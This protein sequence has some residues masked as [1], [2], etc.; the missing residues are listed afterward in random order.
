MTNEDRLRNRLKAL[1]H[2]GPSTGLLE[3][4]RQSGPRRPAAGLSVGRRLIVIV[5]AFAVF[6]ASAILVWR[7][8]DPTG[9]HGTPRS[10]LGQRH[11]PP[12]WVVGQAIRMAKA[13]ED[14]RPTSAYWVYTDGATIAPA[15]GLTPDQ[16][17]AAKEYLVILHGS[18]TAV[19]AKVPSGD[20][21]PTGTVL[22]FT[23]DPKTHEVLD[24]GV[25]DHAVDVAGLQSFSLTPGGT[26]E[27][28]D[29]VGLP[30]SL[31]YPVGWFA[32]SIVHPADAVGPHQLGVI[33]ANT[34]SGMPSSN[35][36]T[37][38]PGPLPEN[39]NLPPDFVRLT[40][41][42]NGDGQPDP[43]AIDSPLPLSMNDAKH[44][45]GP[46]N[47]RSISATVSGVSYEISIQGGPQ[48]TDSDLAVADAIVASIR[49]TDI[50]PSPSPSSVAP[51]TSTSLAGMWTALIVQGP[52]D[53]MP[54]LQVVDPNGSSTEIGV[55]LSAAWSPD[56][57]SLVS[58]RP[59]GVRGSA[60]VV[61]SPSGSSEHV[62]ESSK[63]VA[64][65]DPSWSPDGSQIAYTAYYAN[66]DPRDIQ[67]VSAEGGAPR[68]LTPRVSDDFSPTWSPDGRTIAFI[69]VPSGIVESATGLPPAQMNQVWT[70]RKDG[71]DLVRLTTMPSG[72]WNPHWDPS[73]SGLAF[74]T[75]VRTYLISNVSGSGS[76]VSEVS[77]APRPPSLQGWL[78]DGRLLV[79]VGDM[80]TRYLAAGPVG[81][82]FTPI[83]LAPSTP[84]LAQASVCPGS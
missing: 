1:D 82:P 74:T 9:T 37:P 61:T 51:S 34:S 43:A 47:I 39:P 11:Q 10:T 6:G 27:Y 45:P 62:I 2:V 4:A 59:F 65:E 70:M 80:P 42:T 30:L 46:V 8:F 38:T 71:S 41:L 28:V 73:T 23:L 76:Q 5:T 53:M 69:R 22:S 13:N 44:A 56:C 15:V 36:V 18:F 84:P 21:V 32:Q 50:T 83:R 19:G 3:R 54:R 24:W 57:T 78:P 17:S 7:A 79:A 64:I 72:A 52:S 63:T 31:S 58:V 20:P 77:S 29:Q 26:I 67:V 49:P 81:G 68:T 12:D 40:I 33:V 48:A 60:L 55:G 75:G 16:A 35:T 25:T 66:G 14:P